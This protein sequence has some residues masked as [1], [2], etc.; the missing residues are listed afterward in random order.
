M[1]RSVHIVKNQTLAMN[2]IKN[3][4]LLV[5]ITYIYDQKKK[6]FVEYGNENR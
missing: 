4:V 5:R 2:P 1:F 3:G 6:G